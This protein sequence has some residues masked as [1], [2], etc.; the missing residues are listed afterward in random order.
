MANIALTLLQQEQRERQEKNLAALGKAPVM[1]G[2][3]PLRPGPLPKPKIGGKRFVVKGKA[4]PPKTWHRS[5]GLARERRNVRRA[6]KG[7]QDWA[8][9][10]KDSDEKDSA[11]SSNT[12]SNNLLDHEQ[13]SFQLYTCIFPNKMY[14]H[15]FVIYIYI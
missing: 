13:G 11:P 1:A 3:V 7:L 12:V 14:T 10:L 15:I 9:V 5:H 6:I 2:P 8:E 4:P